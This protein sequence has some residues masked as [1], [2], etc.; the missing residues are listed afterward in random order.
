M[1]DDNV[2]LNNSE[3][4]DELKILK[5]RITQ[6]EKLLNVQPSSLDSMSHGSSSKILN[7]EEELEITIGQFWFPKLGVSAFI[8]G[9]IFLLTIPFEGIPAI[10]PVMGGYILSLLILGSTYFSQK[11]FPQLTGYLFGGSASIAYLTTLRLYFFGVDH[12]LNNLP[13][14][15]LI[16]M[17][18]VSS[19]LIYSLKIK[20]AYVSALGLLFGYIT[21]LII[22]LP[23]LSF[24]AIL[25][26]SLI[27][28]L[29][30]INNNWQ[31]L[32]IFSSI[33]AYT[34]HITWVINNPFIVSS[35]STNSINEFHLLFLIGYIVIFSFG[36][37]FR[38]NNTEED[39]L[40]IVSSML[41]PSI[42][43]GAFL[44]MSLLNQSNLFGL[45]HIITAS[46][47][48]IVAIA[49]WKKEKSQYSTF[50]YAMTSYA[51]LSVAIIF[52]S[53]K[54]DYFIWLCWQSLLVLSTAVWFKSRFIVV[55]NFIIFLLVMFA[56]LVL[57]NTL[58]VEALSFGIVAL[59][60]ARILNFK[61]EGLELKTELMRNAYL[62]AALLT[63]PY[64]FYFIIPKFF[65][66]ISLI[67]LALIYFSFSRILKIAKYRWMG[68]ITLLIAV[69]YLMIYG[70]TSSE[71]VY[72]I[73]SFLFAGVVLIITSAVYGKIKL[74]KN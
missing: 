71:V 61:K 58:G 45:F 56:Y 32:L 18:V 30:E 13:I 42:G 20:S 3:P 49:F 34:F 17:F 54:P 39:F 60:S 73:I 12:V 46:V 31:G 64:V 26:V 38:K 59:L 9:M 16:L 50:I 72:K 48:M 35:S 14:E 27:A 57:E 24:T 53:Q 51:A 2:S 19:I 36:V 47:L 63:I 1:N 68:T 29:I 44:V 7:D 37:L 41:T 6:L 21:A 15:F 52:L 22:P 40:V 55:A 65:V 25:I 69:I 10:I 8:I 11:S 5:S 74:K 67:G 33:I 43:Y 23:Y 62:L 28:V 66:G 70:I 4:S